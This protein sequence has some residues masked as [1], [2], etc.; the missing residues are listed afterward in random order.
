MK[1][2]Y[3]CRVIINSVTRI[4][5][6][7]DPT[8]LPSVFPSGDLLTAGKNL[9][10]KQLFILPVLAHY[11]CVIYWVWILLNY[12]FCHYNLVNNC[13]CSSPTRKQK[14]ACSN[15]DYCEFSKPKKTLVFHI[16]EKHKT[17]T[18]ILQNLALKTICHFFK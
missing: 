1:F 14:P 3:L 5:L 13:V 16:L 11:L 6:N 2:N 9:Q 7:A 18:E 8:K 12:S 17:C 10:D 15:K 4:S